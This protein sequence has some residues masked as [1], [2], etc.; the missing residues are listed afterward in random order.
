MLIDRHDERAALDRLV[1]AVRGGES[2]ALVLCGKPGIGKTALLDYVSERATGC[3][4]LRATGMQS[5]MQFAF[6]GLHQLCAPLLGSLDRLPAPQREALRTAFAMSTGPA[7]DQF[8]VGLAVLSLLSEAAGEQPLIGLVDDQHWLDRASAQALGFVA[9]RLGADPVGLVFAAGTPTAD[10]A[11]LP[12]LTVRG[13]REEDSRALLTAALP[14]PV[15]APVLSQIIAET[16]GNPLA[17]LELPR[18]LS[19]AELAGGFG[20]PRSR[21]LHNRIEESFR[22]KITALPDDTRLLLLVT[23]A[24]PSGNPAVIWEA[25]KRLGV[26]P[27]AA[28]PAVDARLAEFGVRMLFRHPL[29]RSAAY[30]A[31]SAEERRAAHAALAEAIDPVEDQDRRTWHLAQ[32][33]RSPD[34]TVAAKLEH[35]A[36]RAQ[37]RG[38]LAAAAAFLERA[39]QLTPDPV[40]RSGRLLAAAR[41]KRDAGELDAALGLLAVAETDSLDKP[42]AGE[43]EHLRG[44]IALDQRRGGDAGKL[45][46]SA[47]RRYED[48]QA[49]LAR[50]TYLEAFWAA[51]WTGDAGCLRQA[52]EAARATLPGPGA[53]RAVDVLLD[54]LAVRFTE[55]YTAAAPALARALE[56]L[57]R[58]EVSEVERWTWHPGALVALEMWDFEAWQAI[59]SA[60][61]RKSRET[62]ALVHLQFALTYQARALLLAGDLAG[63]ARLIEE[64]EL[65]AEATGNPP[66]EYSAM[67]LAAW[68]GDEKEASALIEMTKADAVARGQQDPCLGITA[69]FVGCASAVLH[70]GLGQHDAACATVRHLLPS[71][72]SSFELYAPLIMPELGEAAYRSG[73]MGLVREVHAWL[74]Q[75]AS[76]TRTNWAR[77][78]SARVGAFLAEGEEAENLYRESVARL[79][80]TSLRAELARSALL[81]G[82][83][84]RRE[85]RLA[86]ARQ[87]LREAHDILAAAGMRAFAGRARRE[88]ASAG[89]TLPRDDVRAG[90]NRTDGADAELTPQE[91]QIARLA[92]D[93]LSN[94]EIAARLFISPRT[95]QYH[96]GKVFGK[97]GIRSRT[98]LHKVLPG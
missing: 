24:E 17:L 68:R 10:V 67:L 34:E 45:L 84:L 8:H 76:V 71:D 95:V 40:R 43:A 21:P 59:A 33:A 54:S 38:G 44:Q 51:I 22:R 30:Q 23:A 2:R 73:E 39:A 9:R 16:H 46:L 36:D 13:L 83:W 86:E 89:G 14:W 97:L 85:R 4:V 91:A 80:E 82:E 92:A 63:A 47:A 65:I 20:L 35:G 58:A 18:G 61:V 56:L 78:M 75:R 74:R 26:G 1:D 66:I 98:Q 87:P 69:T 7:P 72:P 55:G 77:G 11:G 64:D 81:Y 49:A 90:K 29:A 5:E 31:A 57:E 28:M 62:G 15:D 52:A 3:Q 88:L 79:R 53:R 37:A 94:P 50:T 6:A 32:A 27:D 19:P 12:E 70:N 96:L 60:Q 41:A 42:Q 93:G 48:G 25:A